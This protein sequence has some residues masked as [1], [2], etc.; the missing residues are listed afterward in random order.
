[1]AR[2]CHPDGAAYEE[3][4]WRH[5]LMVRVNQAADAGDLF[6]LRALFREA[7]ART[8]RNGG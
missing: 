2:L 7:L 8:S 1:L 3:A 4:A 5:E 6:S